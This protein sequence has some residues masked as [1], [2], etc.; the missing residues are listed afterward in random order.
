MAH[1]LQLYDTAETSA[2]SSLI[3]IDFG[4]ETMKKSSNLVINQAAPAVTTVVETLIL[5]QKAGLTPKLDYVLISHQDTDHWSLLNY[6]MDAVDELKVPMKVGQ[7]IYGGSDWG[8]GASATVDRLRTYGV[9]GLA[10]FAALESNVSNYVD[11]NGKIGSLVTIDELVLRILIANAPV[12]AKKKTGMHK[13]GTSAVVVI[14]YSSERMILPGDATWETLAFCNT[15][16]KAWTTSPV[17]PVKMVSAPHHGAL[18]SMAAKRRKGEKSNLEQLKEFTELVKPEALIASAGFSNSFKHPY[19]IILDTL[20]KYTIPSMLGAHEIVVYEE[21]TADWALDEGKTESIYTTVLSLDSPVVVADYL[22]SRNEFGFFTE[23]F[24]FY[25]PSKAV[26]S[27]PYTSAQVLNKKRKRDEV[28]KDSSSGDLIG[29]D[30]DSRQ[31]APIAR[32]PSRSIFAPPPQRWM[33]PP[34][35]VSPVLSSAAL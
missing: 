26:V 7:V 12:A 5:Q 8:T 15:L 27:V 23:K 14:D 30:D 4:A 16:L 35:R 21:D 20:G 29:V 2:P 25:G 22:F 33:P 11:A 3:L 1:M 34:R 24:E 9:D 32:P 10:P 6:L 28:E 17:Q 18:A 13:N 19:R 31:P